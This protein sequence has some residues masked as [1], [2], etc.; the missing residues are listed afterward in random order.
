MGEDARLLLQVGPWYRSR[1]SR[2]HVSLK[3]PSLQVGGTRLQ[4]ENGP[5]DPD[6]PRICQKCLHQW[7][8]ANDPPYLAENTRRRLL[9]TRDVVDGCWVWQGAIKSRG[10][11]EI[12]IGR[13]RLVH[14]VS[15]EVF[16]GPIPDGRWVLHRCDNPPCFNPAHLF[17]GDVGLNVQDAIEKGRDGGTGRLNRDKTHCQNGHA[18]TLENTYVAPRG[19]RECRKCSRRA[20]DAYKERQRQRRND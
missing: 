14:R 19:S 6:D 4:A 16:V 10:Y 2:I 1:R 12:T 11:G 8:L 5:L 20:K 7:R 3:C 9:A 18:F 17:L 15:W 13:A